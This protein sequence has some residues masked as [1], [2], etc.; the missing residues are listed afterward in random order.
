MTVGCELVYVKCFDRYVAGS[1]I[2][3]AGVISAAPTSCAS[4]CGIVYGR[5]LLARYDSTCAYI[6]K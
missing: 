5:L 3:C 4:L 1:F 2:Q 6:G